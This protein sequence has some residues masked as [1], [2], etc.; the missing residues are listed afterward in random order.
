MA[1][2]IYDAALSFGKLASPI[3]TGNFPDILNLGRVP[4]SS[5]QYPGK[6]FTN[7]D[8]LTVDVCCD[9]P[10]GGTGIT[11]TV[12]GSADGSSGWTDV[13]KNTFTLADMEAGPCQVAIS[14]NGLQY[15]RVAVTASGT[16]TDGSAEAYLNTYAGK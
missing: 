16:F 14:P 7:A 6:E 5:D 15:L 10:D 3:A 1:N 13:G 11:V 2:L 4:G 9:S 8:R 12:Q